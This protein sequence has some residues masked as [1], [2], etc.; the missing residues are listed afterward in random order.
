MRPAKAVK[1]EIDP[2]RA[3]AMDRSWTDNVRTLESN[4]EAGT[5]YGGRVM[6]WMQVL[7]AWLMGA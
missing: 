7:L 6:A 2:A 4:S 5:R 1:V 3:Y